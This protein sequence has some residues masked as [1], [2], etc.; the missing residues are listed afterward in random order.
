MLAKAGKRCLR[1]SFLFVG[2][3]GPEKEGLPSSSHPL[4]ESGL[5]L[6]IDRSFEKK[7][8]CSHNV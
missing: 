2:K 4:I 6:V 3:L 7:R 1:A 5:V 8:I